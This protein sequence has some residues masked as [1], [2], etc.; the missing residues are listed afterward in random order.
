[1]TKK[2]KELFD[3]AQEWP[4]EAQDQLIDVARDI[5]AGRGVYIAT[6]AE[7]R[8]IDRGLN[9]AREG[10][11]ASKEEVEKSFAAFDA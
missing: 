11:F 4:E 7:L 6:S 10:L 2:L 1:M 9:A 5:E 3:R 8:G